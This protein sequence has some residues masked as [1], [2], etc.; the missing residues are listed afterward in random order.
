MNLESV[1]ALRHQAH[2]IFPANAIAASLTRQARCLIHHFSDRN[3]ELA[4]SLAM[5]ID[6]NALLPNTVCTIQP[7]VTQKEGVVHCART[8]GGILR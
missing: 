2:A 7:N 6:G 3:L 5:H 1:V 8:T 4:P